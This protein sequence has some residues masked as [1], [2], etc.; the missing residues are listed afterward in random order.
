MLLSDNDMDI[1]DWG[2]LKHSPSWP[3]RAP[4]GHR[5]VQVLPKLHCKCHLPG[6]GLAFLC[7]VGA[8][9]QPP[10]VVNFWLSR[11][12]GEGELDFILQCHFP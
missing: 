1:P 4:E 9:V 11:G 6:T 3:Q 8:Q 10:Q 12:P 7:W 5:M 2:H